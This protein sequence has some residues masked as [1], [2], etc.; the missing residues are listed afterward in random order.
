M[1][2][3]TGTSIYQKSY[4]YSKSSN[5][6]ATHQPTVRLPE[7]KQ[8]QILIKDRRFMPPY[9]K[10]EKNSIVKWTL[11]KD[12]DDEE[13]SLYYD[14]CRSHVVFF[15]DIGLESPKLSLTSN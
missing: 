8:Y 9:L 6:A 10:I 1:Y 4:Q 7:P 3:R 5:K 12:T 2:P 14:R 11:V 13:T 15:E